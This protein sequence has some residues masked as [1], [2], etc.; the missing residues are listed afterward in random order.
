MRRSEVMSLIKKVK[1]HREFFGVRPN[2]ED[3]TSLIEDEWARLFEDY[4]YTDIDEILERWLMNEN[5]IGKVPDAFYLR[6]YALTT[7][8]KKSSSGVA[9]Y[10][11]VCGKALN[12]HVREK[13][14]VNR[15]EAD[16][17]MS[18]CRSVRYLKQLYRRYFDREIDEETE[19]DLKQMS[20]E[21]FDTTYYLI[22]EK[23]YKKMPESFDKQL[24]GNTL[25]TR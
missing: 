25:K 16:E 7:E 3:I 23:A 11:E 20:K 12:V 13:K 21:K 8:D 17:H 10:C 15:T 19:T 14:I 22:L 4:D 5:N 6:K 9:I 1:T 2:G 18:R 24:L